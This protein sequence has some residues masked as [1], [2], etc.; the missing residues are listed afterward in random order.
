MP[1]SR[2]QSARCRR[3]CLDAKLCRTD[4]QL[5]SFCH[6]DRIRRSRNCRIDQYGIGSEFD[7]FRRVR[8]QTYPGIHYHRDMTLLYDDLDHITG[9]YPFV[10]ANR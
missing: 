6:A 2:I 7:R 1:L 8:R 10:R 9:A 3:T 4:C 5:E